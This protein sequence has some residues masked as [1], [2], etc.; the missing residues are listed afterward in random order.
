VNLT[1]RRGETVFLMGGNGSGKSSLA[2]LLS[3]LYRP[4]GGAILVDG[5]VIG[6]EDW[7]AYRQLFASVFTDFHL[8]AQLL[9]ADGQNADRTDIEHWLEQLHMKHKVQL[10]AGHLLDTR[11]SQGQRKRLALMLALLEKR[12]ILLLDEWAAD[13]DPLFRRFFYRELL[14]MFKK[15]GITVFAISHDDQYFDLA[16]RLVKMESGQLSELQGDRR[17]NASRDA[18]EEIGAAYQMKTVKAL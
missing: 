2:R 9:G 17:E 4:S 7:M 16:D 5:Q 11:F 1:L 3:G 18:V 14:P 8:F 13:Q 12:D 6:S 15:A 10:G